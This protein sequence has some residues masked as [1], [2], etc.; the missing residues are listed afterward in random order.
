[1][2]VG[3]FTDTDTVMTARYET[4]DTALKLFHTRRSA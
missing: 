3:V 4:K 1:M 2:L